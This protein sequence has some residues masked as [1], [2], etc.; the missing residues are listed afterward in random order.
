M[1]SRTRQALLTALII[2]ALVACGPDRQEAAKQKF[3]SIPSMPGSVLVTT[4]SGIDGG[5]SETCYGGYV[6]AMYGTAQSKAE[7]ITFYRQ[8]AQENDWEIKVTPSTNWLQAVNHEDYAFGV[9][10]VTP[11]GPSELYPSIHIID[12]KV[13]ERALSQFN[14]VYLLDASYY[15]NWKDC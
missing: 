2:S 15:P 3:E 12:P 7:V 6:E 1:R 9:N 8:Y 10:I 11:V 4:V 5:S 13:Y 14:T